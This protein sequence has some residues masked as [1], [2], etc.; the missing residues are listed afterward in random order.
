MD[1]VFHIMSLAS[2]KK[3]GIRFSIYYHCIFSNHGWISIIAVTAVS[4]SSRC[5]FPH[6]ITALFQKRVD[7]V[8]HMLL[9]H[10]YKVADGFLNNVTTVLQSSGCGFPYI[11]KAL[12]QR[13]VNSVY[14]SL[15][16]HI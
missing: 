12:F 8:F 5:R 7:V 14:L 10:P 11:V 16:L 1:K 3:Q 4:H 2:F 9:L 13:A 6:V 15:W